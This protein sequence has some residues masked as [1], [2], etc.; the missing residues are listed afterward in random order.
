[1]V[2]QLTPTGEQQ[3]PHSRLSLAIAAASLLPFATAFLFVRVSLAQQYQPYFGV[4]PWTDVGVLT[5]TVFGV[6]FLVGGY[7]GGWI[8]AS[9]WGVLLGT[10]AHLLAVTLGYLFVLILVAKSVGS[11]LST[12]GV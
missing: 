1:M 12:L 3:K 8:G 9:L 10:T 5:S 7:R 11:W 6:G 4:F 2:P